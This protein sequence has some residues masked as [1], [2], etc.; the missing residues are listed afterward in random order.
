MRGLPTALHHRRRMMTL[1]I[2]TILAAV[3]LEDDLSDAV[4]ETAVALSE[5]LGAKLHVIDA[6]PP[7]EGIGFPYAQRAMIKEI[8]SHEEARQAR[9]AELEA[10]LQRL[11][12][13]ATTFAPVGEAENAIEIYARNENV[14]L[15]V[16]GSH[17]KG[18]WE[19]TI[20]G[21]VSSD[22]AHDAPCAVFLVTKAYAERL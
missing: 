15:L 7:I 19:R 21:T 17:Q 3:D 1:P 5:R 12:P 20:K 11:S 13:S 10:K 18:L 14:D 16:I 9:A 4:I 6:W 2:K 22:V 8:K